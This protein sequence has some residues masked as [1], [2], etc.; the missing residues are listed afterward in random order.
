[1]FNKGDRVV[2]GN[3]GVCAVM[4][5]APME[6]G[7]KD[8]YTLKPEFS[9]E[10]I[11]VPTDTKVFMRAALTKEEAEEL[12]RRIP[13]VKSKRCDNKNATAMKDEYQSCFLSHDCDDLVCLI[14]GIYEKGQRGGKLG[15]IDQRFMKRAEDLLHGELALALNIDKDQVVD[16]ITA[17][18]EK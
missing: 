12:I 9:S 6:K 10:V 7:G 3:T 4:D 8:Y 1:M 5:V 17:T 15:V 2:Y 11:Y 16:Y 13:D 18:I 14:K